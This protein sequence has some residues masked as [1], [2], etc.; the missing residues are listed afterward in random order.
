MVFHR[1]TVDALRG[2]GL[3]DEADQLETRVRQARAWGQ[4][5]PENAIALSYFGSRRHDDLIERVFGG[6][7]DAA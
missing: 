4:T 7:E 3:T 1:L 2:A 5:T 6:L